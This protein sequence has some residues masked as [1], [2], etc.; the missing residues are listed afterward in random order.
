MPEL[1]FKLQ[2]HLNRASGTGVFLRI[3]QDFQEYFFTQHL[4]ITAFILQQVLTLYFAII[5]RWQ[6]SS[7]K[8]HQFGK[9][10]IHISQGFSRFHLHRIY[11]FIFFCSQFFGQMPVQLV[12]YAKRILCSEQRTLLLARKHLTIMLLKNFENLSSIS[13]IFQETRDFLDLT[14]P[15]IIC[16]QLRTTSRN[17]RDQENVRH[18]TSNLL[19]W[20]LVK[21]LITFQKPY[22]RIIFFLMAIRNFYFKHTASLGKQ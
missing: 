9:N 20:D 12:G 22:L 7:S 13:N 15:L 4:W 11:L 16:F 10:F 8:R 18:P 2:L 17:F 21:T 1:L 19:K 3:L 5:Y 6:L 14:D